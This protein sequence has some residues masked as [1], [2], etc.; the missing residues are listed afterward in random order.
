MWSEFATPEIINGR[1]WPRTAAIAER[2]WSAQDV[3]DVPDMYR[4]L[5][6][7][8]AHLENYDIHPAATEQQMLQRIAGPTSLEPV[9][10]LA[11]AV[12]QP[13]G[14]DRE[15]LAHYNAFSQLNRMID[16]VPV[17]SMAAYRFKLL[18]DAVIAKTATPAQL[19][20]AREMLRKWQ[21]NDAAIQAAVPQ[22]ALMSDLPAVSTSLSGTAA[23]GLSAL[24]ATAIPADEKAKDITFLDA[25]SKPQGV[26]LNVVAPI[27]E[28]LV[29]S[30]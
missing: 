6:L 24:D 26:L 8:N 14:Y 27:V 30:K 23:I 10:V 4:R 9:Q 12:E 11:S 1:I 25:A 28:E 3:R 20:E 18:V 16:S 22:S 5:A 19:A 17:Q 29:K 15:G 7:V 21:Q 2:L 13:K